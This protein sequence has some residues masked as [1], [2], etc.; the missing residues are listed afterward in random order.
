[1][2]W[3]HLSIELPGD[4]G[5][6]LLLLL[7]EKFGFKE[8]DWCVLQRPDRARVGYDPCEPRTD[9]GYTIDPFPSA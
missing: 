9:S 5:L 4:D 7:R 2:D 3:M 8:V 1:M 6:A